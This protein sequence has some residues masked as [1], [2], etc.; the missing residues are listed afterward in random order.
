MTNACVIMHDKQDYSCH[1]H[2]MKVKPIEQLP[3]YILLFT[4]PNVFPY[5]FVLSFVT[6]FTFTTPLCWRILYII[7]IIIIIQ[8]QIASKGKM[9]PRIIPMCESPFPLSGVSVSVMVSVAGLLRSQQKLPILSTQVRFVSLSKQAL[10]TTSVLLFNI[11]GF[12][13]KLIL[14]FASRWTV[15]PRTESFVAIVPLI[16]SEA[17]LASVESLTVHLSIN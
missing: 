7:I 9:I 11:N 14:R 2:R 17:I 3:H 15:I 8:Q 6:F 10:H 12:I 5:L 13:V 1:V 4:L 16:S